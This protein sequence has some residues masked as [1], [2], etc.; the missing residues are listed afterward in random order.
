MPN[1]LDFRFQKKK[2]KK[3]KIGE[4]QCFAPVSGAQLATQWCSITISW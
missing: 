3:R 4:N 1:L 2:L